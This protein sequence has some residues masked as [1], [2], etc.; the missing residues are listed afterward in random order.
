MPNHSWIYFL[1]ALIMQR[2]L[3]QAGHTFHITV[4]PAFGE[5]TEFTLAG[6]GDFVSSASCR[7]ERKDKVEA[8]CT[9]RNS[10]GCTLS[11]SSTSSWTRAVFSS[12]LSCCQTGS[13]RKLGLHWCQRQIRITSKVRKQEP[14]LS[15]VAVPSLLCLRSSRSTSLYTTLSS[16]LTP[17]CF[18]GI[19]FRIMN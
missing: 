8:I 16:A 14:S 15:T 1:P 12:T 18:S 13:Q 3:F 2:P 9:P 7:M 19:F 4:L 6:F 10:M 5:I 11:S 17:E